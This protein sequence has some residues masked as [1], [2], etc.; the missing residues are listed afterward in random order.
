MSSPK[1]RLSVLLPILV[2]VFVS[3]PIKGAVPLFLAVAQAQQPAQ[4]SAGGRGGQRGGGPGGAGAAQNTA[5]T[6]VPVKAGLYMVTGAGANTMVRVTDEGV[7]VVDTK[8]IGQGNYDNLMAQIRTVSDK[9]VKFVVIGDVHQDKSG[10]T[11]QFVEAG[12]KVIGH[13]NEKKGLE[14]Y[15]NPAGKPGAPNITYD[16]D[17]SIKLGGKEVARVYHFGAA[18][19]G[20]DSITY[21]PDLKVV[22]MGDVFQAG[23]N[24]DYA[25][26]GS[27][28][29]WPKTLAAVLKLDIETVIPNR[30]DPATRADLQAAQQ[31]VAKIAATAIDLIK[32]TPKTRSSTRSTLSTQVLVVD[33]FLA[34]NA[35]ARLDAFST[36]S[37]KPRSRSPILKSDSVPVL[38]IDVGGTKTVC[39]LGDDEGRVLS[40][41]KGP[42]ANL[43]AVGELQ[44]E[45]VLHTVM[46]ETVAQHTAVPAAICLGIAGVDRPDDA[47]VVRGIMSRIGYKARILVVNDALIALQ[48][49]IGADAG[50]VIVAGT[51]S[52]AYGC[53][54]HGTAARAGGWGYVLGDEGSGYW[55]GRLALRAIVREVD[56]RGQPTSLTPRVLA[57]FGV[58]RP[59]ELLQTVYRHDFKPAAVAALATH[60]QRARDEGDAVATA[61]LDRG[62]KELVA[63]A[64]SVTN[65]LELTDEEFSFVLAGGMFKA[66][67]WLREEITR[68]LPAIAPR[69]APC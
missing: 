51:G 65:Q 22:T 4:A 17:Y 30:G 68:L 56:G 52:I 12:A 14:T 60:V 5:Q 39:L 16:K 28:L 7:L 66:V 15:T 46:E 27:M 59:E 43:Q 25:Q 13:T 20:G 61:I 50:V 55:M 32:G 3:A 42:G 40:T 53:D 31:R 1:L 19:T 8:Q 10:N 34:I 57:H 35:P 58:A 24:C 64:E 41:A 54:R 21:F 38:G 63:A 23:M 45:K 62:A 11:A 47:V 36:S 67:P 44:L 29:E 37:S 49:G 69:S 2:G 26:G 33:R 9:P 18:S 48:A 6:I